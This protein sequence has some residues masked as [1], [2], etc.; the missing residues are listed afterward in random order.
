HD[1][2]DGLGHSL[3]IINAALDP[4]ADWGSASS[5]KPSSLSGGTPGAA[6]GGESPSDDAIVL[7]EV[8]AHSHSNAPDW[9]ELHN[10]SGAAIDVSGWYLSDNEQLLQKYVLP[11]G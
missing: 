7:N 9:I 3:N 10:T 8:L 4:L 6:D 5:W 2:T 1:A 11:E